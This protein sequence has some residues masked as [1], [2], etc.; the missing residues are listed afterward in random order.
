M[1]TENTKT[2]RRFFIFILFWVIIFCLGF[3]LVIGNGTGRSGRDPGSGSQ[4]SG[5]GQG[6]GT[7]GTSERKSGKGNAKN[8]RADGPETT[9]QPA[10]QKN[11]VAQ[12]AK[13]VSSKPVQSRTDNPK[14]PLKILST[15]TASEDTA[16]IYRRGKSTGSGSPAGTSAGFFGVEITGSSIFLLDISGSMASSSAE[17]RSRLDLVKQEMEN[18][19]KS[20][21]KDALKRK[22]N[23]RFRIVCFSSDCIFFPEKDY[24]GFKFASVEQVGAAIDFVKKLSPNGGTEMKHAWDLIIPILRRDE[25]KAVY[26]LSDGEPTDCSPDGLLAQLKAEVPKLTIHTISMGKPSP[27]LQSIA[28]QHNGQYREVY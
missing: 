2:C 7:V 6:Q 16:T 12:P 23:D 24:A 15:E 10:V 13:V 14:A 25:I 1:N 18:T 5:R 17:G 9:A 26:F 22:S 8:A 19:L 4:G 11:A 20:K 28:K 3:L 27:L 21:Y